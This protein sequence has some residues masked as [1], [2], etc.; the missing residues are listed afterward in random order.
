MW[1][2]LWI[3]NFS[4][5]FGATRLDGDFQRQRRKEKAYLKVETSFSE[6][7]IV[8]SISLSKKT[9]TKKLRNC[10]LLNIPATLRLKWTICK[11]GKKLHVH[12]NKIN[13][14][15]L[16]SIR[17]SILFIKF[18]LDTNRTDTAKTETVF[19]IICSE[20]T[21]KKVERTF[22]NFYMRLRKKM[23]ISD[24]KI[25]NVFRKRLMLNFLKI[26]GLWD[27]PSKTWAKREC[28]LCFFD[29]KKFTS[30]KYNLSTHDTTEGSSSS[31]VAEV[32]SVLSFSA[33]CFLLKKT[34]KNVSWRFFFWHFVFLS[35]KRLFV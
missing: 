30:K 17:T 27:L 35:T 12:V 15:Q 13:L 22:W 7:F 32:S 10:N 26:L 24:T 19:P 4:G 3:R 23:I 20:K 6:F 14:L 1:I 31:G 16:I 28:Y 34:Q 18:V 11:M 25:W 21:G 2:N 8:S 33:P 29:W 9:L 5:S